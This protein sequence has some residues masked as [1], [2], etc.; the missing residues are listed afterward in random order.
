MSA[1]LTV[2]SLFEQA[3]SASSDMDWSHLGLIGVALCVEFN[4]RSGRR[5]CGSRE[6]DTENTRGSCQ[7]RIPE[8][9]GHQVTGSKARSRGTFGRFH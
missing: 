4:F 7:G 8:T 6:Q 3:G 2:A 5:N 1:E 9:N